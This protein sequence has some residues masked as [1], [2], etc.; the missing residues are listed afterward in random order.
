MQGH[1][2]REVGVKQSGSCA[3]SERFA[4]KKF[5]IERKGGDASAEV[6]D[7]NKTLANGSDKQL[8]S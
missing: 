7:K 5:C 8:E 1:K 2:A 4:G 6:R 3:D